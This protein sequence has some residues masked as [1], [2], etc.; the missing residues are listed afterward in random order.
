MDDV[1]VIHICMNECIYTRTH[2]HAHTNAH[3]YRQTDTQTHTHQVC[4]GDDA[5][6]PCPSS[7]VSLLTE[8]NY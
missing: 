8:L 7:Q 6:G 4:M 1:A 3:I 5:G 2:K